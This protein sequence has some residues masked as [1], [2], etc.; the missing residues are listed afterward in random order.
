MWDGTTTHNN[1]MFFSLCINLS[2][3]Y[4]IWCTYV[5]YQLNTYRALRAANDNLTMALPPLVRNHA[6]TW[7]GLG[8]HRQ[9]IYRRIARVSARWFDAT[10]EWKAHV[11][12]KKY[13]FCRGARR[14]A[15]YRIIVNKIKKQLVLRK[16]IA[17]PCCGDRDR[18][19][20]IR[21]SHSPVNLEP[22]EAGGRGRSWCRCFLEVVR[23]VV[24]V[25]CG[26]SA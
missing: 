17:S 20:D 26:K 25:C 24:V 15:A 14:S 4:S 9:K 5:S 11:F 1:I 7:W 18:S 16:K 3:E 22:L 13:T 2:S 10:A 6:K 23:C 12:T 21:R 8:R 19:R